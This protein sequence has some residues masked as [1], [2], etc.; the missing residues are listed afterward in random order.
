VGLGRSKELILL[1]ETFSAGEALEMGMIN[2][3]AQPEDME[4]K[5]LAL[6]LKLA[7]LSPRILGIQKDIINKWLNLGHDLGA[8]YSAHA[9]ALS[10]AEN[11]PREG[12]EAFLE[13]RRPD[14]N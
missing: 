12:M 1:G 13:K 3:V 11:D 6:A 5:T 14:Y 2:I 10:F 7:A 4:K 8:E 9:F